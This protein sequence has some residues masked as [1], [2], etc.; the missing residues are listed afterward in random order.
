MFVLPTVILKFAQ[1]LL[2]TFIG[3]AVGKWN[4]L[5]D[6]TAGLS[7]GLSKFI[8][9]VTMPCLIFTTV[10]SYEFTDETMTNGFTVFGFSLVFILLSF[11]VFTP[12]CRRFFKDKETADIHRAFAM[13]TN[14]AFM[15]IPVLTAAFGEEGTVYA[16]FY[17]LANDILLWTLGIVLISGKKGAN[18]KQSLKNLINPNIISFILAITFALLGLH[19]TIGQTAVYKFLFSETFETNMGVFKEYGVLGSLGSFTGY[20]SMFF[21]GLIMAETVGKRNSESGANYALGAG[22][23]FVALKQLVYPVLSYFLLYYISNFLFGYISGGSAI[24]PIVRRVVC[25]QLAMPPASMVTTI[26]AM[27]D[28]GGKNASAVTLVAGTALA[29]VTLPVFLMFLSVAP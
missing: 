1:L 2:I 16:V 13:F 11:A 19:K 28:V 4:Y 8:V 9:K 29:A 14:C 6:G 25:L 10:T 12:Y 15:G 7:K 5:T 24:E 26:A 23:G 21:V 22:V 27:Y 17:Q 3:F 18:L 20:L